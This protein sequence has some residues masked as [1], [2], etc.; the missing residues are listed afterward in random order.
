MSLE[1]IEQAPPSMGTANLADSLEQALLGEP[2]ETQQEVT[3][4][5]TPPAPEPVK[6]PAPTK[7][8]P[9]KE[10]EEVVPKEDDPNK[11]PIDE[12]DLEEK[13][14]EIP[15]DKAGYRIQELKAEI[16]TQ[17]KPKIAELEQTVAQKDA[18][19]EEL[20]GANQELETLKAKISDYEMEMSVIRLEKTEAYKQQVSE[21]IRAEEA[22]AV[23]I[24][25]RYN[26]DQAQLFAALVEP[27]R[28]KRNS[29][30]KEV[31]NGLG[32][33]DDDRDELRDIAKAVQPLFER[34]RELYNNADKALAELE[35]RAEQ[36]SA[37]QAAARAEARA[38]ST[39]LA[40]QRISDKIP[41]LKDIV[42]GVAGSVKETNFEKLDPLNQSY[43]ALAGAALPKIAKQYASLLAERDKLLDEIASYS[44]ATPRVGGGFATT[45]SEDRPKNFGEAMIRGLGAV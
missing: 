2:V 17:Y 29:A 40:A 11:L 25:D 13:I 36:E 37:S 45:A 38:K 34:Q 28:E 26:L 7:V 12:E 19:I 31:I 8:D 1:A 10:L 41:F 14:E 39:D 16:K 18:R 22:K 30:L 33:D 20:Q 35:A 23:A 21:P 3:Q 5:V 15:K 6:T 24:A 44:K 4:E 42:G 27:N 43:N 9:I 32:M